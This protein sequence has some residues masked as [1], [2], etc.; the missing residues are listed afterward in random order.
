MNNEPE[1]QIKEL[2]PLDD[3]P[4]PMKFS[5]KRADAILNHA[6]DVWENERIQ[7][8]PR[9]FPFKR[10][11]LLAAAVFAVSSAAALTYVWS[12][13]E[14]STPVAPREVPSPV[15]KKR[16]TRPQPP[17]QEVSSEVEEPAVVP[18]KTVTRNHN[19]PAPQRVDDLMQRANQ[20]L[21][22]KRWRDAEQTY[23]KVYK[24]YPGTMS[25]YVALV[26]AAS[27]RLEHLD[28]PKGAIALYQY[29]IRSNPR[30]ALDLEA[31]FG[32][33][34]SW[35]ELGNRQQEIS[36]LETLLEK[37]QSGPTAR[38]A[39]QRLEAIVGDE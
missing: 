32:I 6:L 34:Q 23:Y 13:A 16:S 8:K 20:L 2:F 24:R 25:A 17:P 12:P 14:K 39:Q 11:A 30:G 19:K 28:N 38:N 10:V 15:Q 21:Q 35:R 33:A 26:A 22:Q 4:G 27:I 29:A 18:E 7:T 36:A 9:I 1:Y 5:N 31:H 3:Q 37:Y